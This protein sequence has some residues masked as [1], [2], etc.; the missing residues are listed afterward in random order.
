[1]I[2]VLRVLVTSYNEDYVFLREMSLN[3][4]FPT[5]YSLVNKLN[6]HHART[7]SCLLFCEMSFHVMSYLV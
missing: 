5:I 1:M 2:A 4:I 7:E 3:V 6:N